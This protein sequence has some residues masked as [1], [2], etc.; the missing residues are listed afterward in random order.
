MQLKADLDCNDVLSPRI[1]QIAKDVEAQGPSHFSQLVERFKTQP[2]P[3]KPPTNAPEQK[4]YDE[5]LL[6]LLLGV[7][8]DAK[9][10]GIDKDS[11][12]LQETLV[13]GL[14]K[15]VLQMA[16]HQEKMKRDLDVEEAEQKKKI[17]SDDIHEG[18]DSHVSIATP[19]FKQPPLTRLFAVRPTAACTPAG[20][21]SAYR[22]FKGKGE[23][24]RVRGFEPQ[25]CRRGAG[26]LRSLDFH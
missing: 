20:Q 7:W 26:H 10:E 19:V 6:S 2:S 1:K 22:T 5:M 17:T 23:G 9:K 13:K 18:F 4:T 16:E 3:E 8:E 21:R 12:R 25:R 24:Y 15:H 14:E 11:P